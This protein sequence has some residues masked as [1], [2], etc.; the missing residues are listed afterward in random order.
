M[1]VHHFLNARYG[2]EDLRE[3]RLRISR[4]MD[5][6][7]PFEFLGV[8]LGD[9]QF[10][11][12]LKK[13]KQELSEK[14]GI[15]C[16]SKSWRNPVLWGHYA[17][18]HKGLCLGFEIPR[19]ILEKVNY[20]DARWPVPNVPDLQFMKRVLFTKFS[21]WHYEQEYR[22][23]VSLDTEIGG[24]YF[25]DLSSKLKLKRVIVGYQSTVSRKDVG[26]A[27]KGIESEVEVFRA[28]AAFRS[29]E[30]VRNRDESM[31]A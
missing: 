1:L 4:I 6:N 28:R 15:L 3:R 18:R 2:L 21:H 19:A 10:R 26:E 24:H 14:H 7:D 23:F 9:R 11:W 5:L 13:T 31:W 12:A 17:D 22:A 20:I 30:V 25:M 27:I 16:F 29:F 8:D